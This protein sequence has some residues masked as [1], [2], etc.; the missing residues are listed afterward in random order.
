MRVSKYGLVGIGI[1]PFSPVASGFLSGMVNA[2]TDFSHVDDVRKYVPQLSQ[3]NINGNMPVLDLLKR[4]ADEKHATNAQIALAW[5]LKKYPNVVPIPGSKNQGRI[6]EN[7][8]S[9]NI[10]LS[11]G[12][13]KALDE[14]LDHIE[15]H[16]YRGFVQFEGGK[17]SDWGK[18]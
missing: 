8:A 1:V 10:E 11:D 2:G 17:M 16:G 7:L 5:M 18:A 13:L 9:W 15:I 4:F 14:A 3:E 12:E 6:L